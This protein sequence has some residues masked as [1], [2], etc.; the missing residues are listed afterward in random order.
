MESEVVLTVDGDD[1]MV[2]APLARTDRL[3]RMFFRTIMGAMPTDEG[4]RCPRRRTSLAFTILRINTFLEAKGWT[5]SRV[6][7]VDETVKKAEE[8]QRSF[9]RAKEHAT[10]LRTGQPTLDLAA[11]TAS[12]KG[13][14]WD[15]EGRRLRPHQQQGLLH[16]LT[17][18][19]AANFSVPG[20]GKTAIALGIAVTHLANKTVDLVLVVGPLASFAPWEREVRAAV[21]G[22]LP[23]RRIR[24]TAARRLSLYGATNQ[25]ELLLLSFATA[26]ADRRQLEDLCARFRVMLVVDESHRVKR[27]RGGLWAPALIELAKHTRVRLI[28]SGTPMPQSGKDL[29]SQLSVLWPGGEL[30]GPRDTFA[31]RADKDF[32]GLLTEIQPFIS[33]TPKEELGLKPYQL[34]RHEVPI[35]GTQAEVYELIESQ[36][37][38]RIEDADSWQQKIAALRRAKPIRL[39]QAA[40]NPDL[41]NRVDGYYRLPRLESATPTLMQRLASY[42]GSELPAKSRFA[43]SLVREILSRN[44]KV[45]C[46]S[47]FVPNLDQFAELVRA[48]TGAPCFQIDGR[49]ATADEAEDQADSDSPPE[50]ETR[51]R[52]IEQF[53]SVSGG[54]V[55]VT[56][57]ASCS[58]SISLH[59]TCH[60]VIYLDRTYDC[61]LFLQS[62]DRVHRL[63][64]PDQA[65]VMI[66]VL[67]ATN[68]SRQTIDHLVDASLDRKHANMKQLLEGAE[69]KPLALSEEPLRDAEGTDQD[70]SD[71]LHFLLGEEG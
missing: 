8:R 47:N 62:I 16:G 61:A 24:G 30:T 59:R 17:A 48:E 15:D 56:N 63:G 66:H 18:V 39:L 68:A 64:L 42:R 70:L 5:V 25:G 22:L 40:A 7:I 38:K 41:L 21:H 34:V 12:L 37:R 55:L 43:L 23:T 31:A 45:V 36:F 11:V 52:I 67:L 35:S 58:E 69:L 57:P 32:A 1:V 50:I 3:A 4:W 51:E 33:R 46:W 19:N 54:A 60:N 26:A 27:F 10:A 9:V 49:V 28:L 6:G 53:L 44:E 20:S 2:R 65:S 71:L 29:Y 14:G 13:F